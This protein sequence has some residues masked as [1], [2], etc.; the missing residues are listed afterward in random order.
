MTSVRKTK[1]AQQRLVRRSPLGAGLLLAFAVVALLALVYEVTRSNQPARRQ[2]S[3]PELLGRPEAVAMLTTFVIAFVTRDQLA[4]LTH[5]LH[6]RTR[7]VRSAQRLPG[8]GPF[9]QVLV[10]N[11][12]PGALTIRSVRF[13]WSADGA[14]G[15]PF[16]PDVTALRAGLAGLGLTEGSD[17]WL[18]NFGPGASIASSTKRVYFEGTKKTTDALAELDAVFVFETA[19]GDTYEKRLLLCPGTDASVAVL[20]NVTYDSFD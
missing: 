10:E 5:P 9:W 18:V 7:W 14:E 4:R 6:Y 3:W 17:Y 1:R 15:S 13:Y 20:E 12:G 2:A 8:P 11:A 16:A 19:L